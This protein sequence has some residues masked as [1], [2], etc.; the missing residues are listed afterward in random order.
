[1][2]AER[3]NPDINAIAERL[4][5]QARRQLADLP[6]D[7]P[8]AGVP[9]AIKD[10]GIVQKGVPT[11]NGS[12]IPPLTPDFDSVLTQ[13]YRAAGLVTIATSTTPEF[14]L[15]LVTES[16]AFGTTRNPWNTAH[17]SGG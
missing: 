10:L 9:F 16:A 6:A 13:R 5:D 12:R 4:Y 17:T 15:R 11:N 1:A 8:L 2:R 14:G 7:A 3:I